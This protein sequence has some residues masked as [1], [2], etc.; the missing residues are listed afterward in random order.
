R[1]INVERLSSI[2]AAID[3]LNA[4]VGPF[5]R[6][7]I[8]PNEQSLAAD[9]TIPDFVSLKITGGGLIN[10]SSHKLVIKG[11]FEAPA[12]KVFAGS[13]EVEFLGRVAAVYP[14]WFDARGDGET[15]DTEALNKAVFA[16]STTG[17]P[18]ALVGGRT[19]GVSSPLDGNASNAF[20]VSRPGKAILKP[21]AGNPIL[22]SSVSG[23]Y[24]GWK[25]DNVEFRGACGLIGTRQPEFR[26]CSF[27]V[28]A[29]YAVALTGVSS[30]RLIDPEFY[31]TRPGVMASGQQDPAAIS[32]A[33]YGSALRLLPGT[34]D[35][36][37][38]R[39]KIHFCANG[40]AAD[41][42]T[43][44]PMRG[45]YIEDAQVRGDWWNSP[46]VI[47]RFTPTGYNS[48]TG[49][50]TLSGGGFTGF[51][52]VNDFH[53]VS[54]PIGV[55][56]GTSFSSLAGNTVTVA[57]GLFASARKGDSLETRDGK[58]AEILTV[59]SPASVTIAGW[60]SVDTYEPTTTPA[61][62][63]SWRLTRYYGTAGTFISD[64][65]IQLYGDPV[66][67]F[68]GERLVADAGLSPVG[69]NCK[70]MA[71][72]IYTGVH[73]NGGVSD[74]Q[75]KGGKFRGSR[76]DQISIFD[77][78]APKVIGATVDYGFDEGVTITRAPRAIISKN[79]F[80]QCGVSAVAAI[81]SP[82]ASITENVVNNWGT[83]NRNGLG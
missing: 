44:Q 45:L 41:T 20:F 59:T 43:S 33:I 56:N 68:D 34:M 4:L 78:E 9:L 15:N 77:S 69:K 76:A 58:R 6:T 80:E 61:A 3:E 75:L 46:F 18:V 49:V 71:T 60:E 11:A 66:N 14:E 48:S 53:I 28:A 25:F 5:Y 73:L 37:L 83:V 1:E 47:K 82:N 22:D 81:E 16:S 10:T 17:S 65:T 30:P 72:M 52:G 54:I 7:L 36:Q 2:D 29:G 67:P 55:T 74:F 70:T 35:V 42:T 27:R 79:R 19:Y 63:A 32:S 31:G 13:G 8:I 26:Q 51:F 39:P 12:H 24:D 64:T 21:L 23:K 40:I 62:R 38:I 57:G 50:L